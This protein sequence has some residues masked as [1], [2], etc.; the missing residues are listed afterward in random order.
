MFYLNGT[1]IEEPIGFSG[2]YWTRVRH[3]DYFG[4]WRHRTA[5]VMGV[6][7][8]GFAGEARDLL[9]ALWEK[10]KTNAKATFSVSEGGEIVYEAD[11]D[12]GIWSDNG[13]YFNVSFRDEDTELD[14]L[15][16]L[17][18]ALEP[19]IQILFPEQPISE[20]INYNISNDF[21]DPFYGGSQHSVPF[22]T[23]KSGEGNGLTVEAP[24]DLEP[25]YRNGTN[26]KSIL[27]LQ[28]T[29]VGIWQGIGTVSITAEVVQE[30]GIKDS[31]L[32]S[33]FNTSA[34]QQ[35]AYVLENIE[36]QPGAY[37][38]LVVKAGSGLNVSYSAESYLT[39]YENA[40][41]ADTLIWGLTWKQAIEGLLTKLTAGK[42]ALSSTYL[43]KGNGASRTLT[44]ERN[45]RGYRSDL[46][47][48]FKSIWDDMNAIDNLACWRRGSV[49]HIETKADMIG[50]VGRS[51]ITDFETLVHSP[52]PNFYS[53]Y[54]VG[55]KN[56][57]SGT[58]AGRE[59][60]CTERTYLTEQQKVKSTLPI[61]VNNM[62]ASGKTMEA[63][64]RNPNSDKADTAQD[65]QLFV[66]VAD[67]VGSTY[68][69][70][71]GNVEG[72]INP[73]N[74]INADISPRRMLM[75]WSNILG[76]NGPAAFAS[77]TGNITAKCYEVSESAGVAPDHVTQIFTDQYVM[78]ETGMS[79]HQY[80]DAG[81]V[82][83]YYDHDGAEKSAL[84]MEDSYRFT[85]GKVL[86]KAIQLQ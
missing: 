59:E 43:S 17:T 21:T 86:I 63:L 20:G 19:Q 44:S 38:R 40:E 15:S 12:F 61:M 27:Q 16:S 2:V 81:E 78:I 68:I 22:T 6:G 53:S 36:I 37:L 67:K 79:M 77:G 18:V 52:S 45:I 60:F 1:E 4:V 83:D 24:R 84:I 46:L 8:V 51:R 70:R 72:V 10:D 28:G 75:R 41:V 69:S 80:S 33:V 55:Y 9:R 26:R 48:S 14:S 34:G 35:N 31:R 56:W 5:K 50:K 32:V 23:N 11:I 54:Q 39:I 29:I 82:I 62:S 73:A 13:R 64:R 71:T 76:V 42:V 57:Q 25:I 65:E 58:S 30:G 85:T 49:L 3:P 7:E 47:V 66:I 74:V